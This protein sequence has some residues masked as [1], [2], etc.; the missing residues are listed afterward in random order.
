MLIEGGHQLLGLKR[1]HPI[2]VMPS[3]F[4]L[5]EE[6]FRCVLKGHEY[7]H[8]RDYSDGISLGDVVLN[9]E[10]CGLVQTDTFKAIL[11][12]RAYA[13]AILMTLR[14]SGRDTFLPTLVILATY[15]TLL[16]KTNPC[17]DFEK[18]VLDRVR[19]E[20]ERD[21]NHIIGLIEGGYCC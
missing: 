17:S 20:A 13:N 4:E 15:I 9:H 1:R 21:F 11:E 7:T 16:M 3:A 8:A 10:N 6:E 12:S 14:G 19:H 5:S 18:L 2:F